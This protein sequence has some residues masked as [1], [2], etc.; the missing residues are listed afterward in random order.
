M[1]YR[2]A[3]MFVVQTESVANTVG[4]MYP[5]L[6][7]VRTVANPLPEDVISL[8]KEGV[9][10]ARKTLLSL[11]RL[12]D[13]KQV[14]MILNAFASVASDHPDWDLRI[15][16]DGP[17]YGKL[18][19]QIHLLGLQ[20]RAFLM[21]RTTTPWLVMAK[22]DAFVMASK[23][24]GFP[25][26]LLESMAIGLPC[27]AFDCPSGPREISLEGKVALLVPLNDETALAHALQ[28]LMGDAEFR[29]VLGDKARASV[30]ERFVLDKI[31][32]QWDA[33]FIEVGV[34]P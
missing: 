33:L 10:K 24:E 21:G 15:Y 28:Q 27:V 19:S 14:A 4:K 3:D 17:I 32:Q 5:H 26:A 11:G 30:I 16:G 31:L 34:K 29:Q 9:E 12:S 1:A 22:A 20:H 6:K 2:F 8:Q 18:E 7:C 23:Y 25:N 13:E